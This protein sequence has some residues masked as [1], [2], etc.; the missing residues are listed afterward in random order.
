[1][2]RK[3]KIKFTVS[4]RE[5]IGMNNVINWSYFGIKQQSLI[6]TKSFPT[7]VV[8]LWKRYSLKRSHE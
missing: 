4:E 5:V 8:I 7:K 6:G 2:E 3:V 1:M